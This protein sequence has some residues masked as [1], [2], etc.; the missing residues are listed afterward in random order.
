MSV[1]KIWMIILLFQA[2]LL[3]QGGLT[4][5]DFHTFSM[6]VT[7]PLMVCTL[8]KFVKKADGQQW[9]TVTSAAYDIDRNLIYCD[10]ADLMEQGKGMLANLGIGKPADYVVKS[11]KA[12][13]FGYTTGSCAAAASKAAAAMLMEKRVIKEILLTLPDGKSLNLPVEDAELQD[14][15]ASCC[16]VKDAGDDPDVT[17]GIKIYA[18][19][20]K[21]EAGIEIDGGT[22]VGRVTAAGLSCRIGEAAINPGPRRMI[23]QALEEVRRDHA[24]EGGFATEIYV[25]QGLEIA[26]RTFNERLGIV[27]GIS[28]LGTTGIVEPMSESSIIETI[29]LELNVRKEKGH[30]VLL[31]APGNYG[32]D[33]LKSAFGFDIDRAVKCSNYIGETLDHALYLGFERL[34]LVGHIGKLVKLAAGVMNTHSKIADCRNEIFASHGALAGADRDTV[35]RIMAA[36]TTQEIHE[37]LAEQG[38]AGDVYR[39]I[40]EKVQ[41][42]IDYRVMNKMEIGVLSFSNEHGVLFQT[43]NADALIHEL[44]GIQP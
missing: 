11:G 1:K 7:G 2:I 22:G 5:I 41:F 40:M 17:H 44:R 34:L 38:I 27:G 26:K 37:I 24:Y 35:R 3:A 15:E 14:H 23:L 20:R 28:I 9:Q 42:N 39:G 10:K 25:P 21:T 32:L 36:R 16:I 4:T 6:A 43:G 18:K 8:F 19:V 30:K 12:L 13:R 31:V 29:K 33:F